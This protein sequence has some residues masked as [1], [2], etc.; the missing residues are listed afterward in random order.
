M[1]GKVE[2]GNNSPCNDYKL[3]KPGKWGNDK[4]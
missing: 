1:S 4:N 2:H 3:H